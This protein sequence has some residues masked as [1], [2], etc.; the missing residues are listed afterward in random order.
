[1]DPAT[2]PDQPE[3]EPESLEGTGIENAAANDTP[4][5]TP[6]PDANGEV[7]PQGDD[8]EARSS[9]TPEE[10]ASDAKK[11]KTVGLLQKINIYLLIFGLVII[12]GIAVTVI[13]FIKTPSS[14]TTNNIKPQNLSASQLELLASG[15]TTIGA[16][17]QVLNIVPNSIF[18]GQVLIRKDLDV[19]GSINVSQAVNLTNVTVSGTETV[20]TLQASKLSL[21]GNLAIQGQVAVNNTLAVSGA[22]SFGGTLTAKQLTVQSLDLAGDLTISQHIVTN[23]TSPSPSSGSAVGTGG[24]VSLNGTDSAGSVTINTGASPPAG[25]FITVTFNKSFA[26]TPHVV[27]TPV[28]S[29][30]G[31]L[32]YYVNRS[33]ASF[34]ICTDSA[35][36]A[37]TSFGFDY[38][39]ID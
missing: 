39:V 29:A 23:G 27:V 22:A 9:L 28:G 12:I 13:A 16:S 15:S 25:C 24:T 20:Q 3:K 38:I 19:A 10:K 31:G 4:S 33:T 17:D 18:S 5:T 2:P 26:S 7:A 14:S 21:S 36:P 37:S 30:A 34:S 8:V 11:E 6:S 35:A 1:M 32:A